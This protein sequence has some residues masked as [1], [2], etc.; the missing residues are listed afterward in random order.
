MTEPV[1]TADFQ[2]SVKSQA[3]RLAAFRCCYCRELMGDHVHHIIPKEKGGTNDLDN[4]MLLCVQCHTN[5]GHRP[6]KRK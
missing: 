1:A 6:D 3:R 4:T 5:Y 2:E